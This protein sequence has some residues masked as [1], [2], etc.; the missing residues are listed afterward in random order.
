V[1]ALGDVV[2]SARV[3][4]HAARA[5]TADGIKVDAID[6]DV[7]SG[8]RVLAWNLGGAMP[9]LLMDVVYTS[10]NKPAEEKEPPLRDVYCGQHLIHLPSVDY[11]FRA[12]EK[13]ISMPSGS[14]RVVKSYLDYERGAKDSP[15]RCF[16]YLARKGREAEAAGFLETAARISRWDPEITRAAV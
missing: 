16:S 1:P 9:V 10:G 12:P 3:G 4:K 15:R 11:A 14:G 5:A 6:L 2:I 7:T 13:S 8:R